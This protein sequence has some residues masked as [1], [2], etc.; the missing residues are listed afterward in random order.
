ML[1]GTILE[2]D[3]LLQGLKRAEILSASEHLQ[4]A[5]LQSV[6]HELKTPLSAVRTGIDALAREVGQGERAA[7][8]H[9]A[10]ANQG[11]ARGC[12]HGHLQPRCDAL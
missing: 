7:G 5:L 1:I 3:H 11:I 10:G 12:A 6:S 8:L 2:K 9:G 4:R